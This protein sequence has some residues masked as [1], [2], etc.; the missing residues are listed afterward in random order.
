M[1]IANGIRKLKFSSKVK[2]I[3]TQYKFVRKYPNPK[4][5]P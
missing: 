1:I 2:D 5:Q 4:D 3:D